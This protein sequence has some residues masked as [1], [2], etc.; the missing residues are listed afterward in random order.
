MLNFLALRKRIKE[1]K[2]EHMAL[3]ENSYS[4]RVLEAFRLE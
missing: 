3:L 4:E 2:N 1:E